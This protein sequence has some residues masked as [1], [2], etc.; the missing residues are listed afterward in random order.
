MTPTRP[1]PVPAPSQRSLRPRARRRGEPVRNARPPRHRGRALAASSCWSSATAIWSRSC[2]AMNSTSTAS[3]MACSPPSTACRTRCA[4]SPDCPSGWGHGSKRRGCGLR[5]KTVRRRSAPLICS[6][7]SPMRRIC[8]RAPDAWPLLSVVRDADR[9]V[10]RGT[11]PGVGR[12]AGR[13][14]AKDTRARTNDRD[15]CADAGP[16][17]TKRIRSA[18]PLHHRHHAEGARR[19]DRPRVRTRRRDPADGRYPRA[20]PQEQSDP[21]R[22]AGRRQDR[23]GRRAG[24]QDC[25]RRRA[26]RDPRRQRPHARPRTAASGRGRQ[27]RIRA[28]PEE[29]DRSGPAVARRRSCFSSTRRTR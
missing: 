18:A 23:A 17:A 3:G 8:L 1:L 26:R 25:R 9:A 28:A 24:A 6:P 16:H 15:S 7:P 10:A 27:G 19:Q 14:R 11:R 21:R 20:A 5:S 2:A 4:A 29:R 22:R 12:S 13:G